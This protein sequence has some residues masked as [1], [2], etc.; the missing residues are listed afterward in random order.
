MKYLV[1]DKDGEYVNSYSTKLGEDIS[2]NSAIDCAIRENGALFF[3][4]EDGEESHLINV[5]DI[6]EVDITRF[7]VKKLIPVKA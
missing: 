1:K 2:L 4:T 5:F 3:V 7:L 6:N